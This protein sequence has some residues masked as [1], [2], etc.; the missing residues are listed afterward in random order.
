MAINDYRVGLRSRIVTIFTL[1]LN[2][3]NMDIKEIGWEFVDWIRL[4]NDMASVKTEAILVF[5]NWHKF[6]E[7][8][9]DN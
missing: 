8:S 1:A 9:K 3:I 2:N 5:L 4:A 7:L 6:S